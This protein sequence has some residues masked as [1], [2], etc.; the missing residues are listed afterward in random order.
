L[1]GWKGGEGGLG[2]RTSARNTHKPAAKICVHRPL[3][4]V[5]TCPHHARWPHWLSQP[6]CSGCRPGQPEGGKGAA[7]PHSR[8]RSQPASLPMPR[9]EAQA[10]PQSS[11]RP[12]D[13]ERYRR[14]MQRRLQRRWRPTA[15]WAA[16]AFG[17]SSQRGP[18]AAVL[19]RRLPGAAVLEEEKRPPR[20]HLLGGGAAGVR[21]RRGGAVRGAAARGGLGGGGG[22][23][24]ASGLGRCGGPGLP[25]LGDAA[26]VRQRAG[27]SRGPARSL[28]CWVQCTVVGGPGRHSYGQRPLHASSPADIRQR[29]RQSSGGVGRFF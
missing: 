29:A 27:A 26:V 18:P 23:G 16:P 2:L 5:L 17:A 22:G 8:S 6:C 10:S 14:T 24:G 9:H 21:A 3:A 13:A 20:R 1:R 7:A 4:A 12:A 28:P 19:D 15:G 11:P 25:G